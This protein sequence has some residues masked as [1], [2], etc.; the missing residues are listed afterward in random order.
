VYCKLT[1][2]CTP[3]GAQQLLGQLQQVAVKFEPR[4]D[5]D[6]NTL[7]VGDKVHILSPSLK[8]FATGV[9]KLVGDN[10]VCADKPVSAM[11]YCFPASV[12]QL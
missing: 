2:S 5:C 4:I 6:N 11:G 9:I 10:D 8:P 7:K 12:P 3:A 1:K